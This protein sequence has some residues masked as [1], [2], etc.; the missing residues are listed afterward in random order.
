MTSDALAAFLGAAEATRL[1]QKN[2]GGRAGQAGTIYEQLFGAHRIS[3]LMKNLI[4]VGE[5]ADVEWPGDGFV[6]DFVVRKDEQLSFAAY[7]LKNAQQ[8]SWTAN[9]PNSI[10]DDFRAQRRI[11]E[12]ERYEKIELTLVCS[13][14]DVR[15]RL[16][17]AVPDE[18][19]PF[20][21]V[22]FFPFEG[23]L[24]DLMERHA[25]LKDDFGQVSRFDAPS[26]VQAEQIARVL[27]GLLPLRDGDM[28]VRALLK[29]A[30]STSPQ[31][32]R[33]SE[34]DQQAMQHVSPALR[35]ILEQLPGFSY[36]IRRGF[37][38][39]SVSLGSSVTKGTL[40]FD[41]SSDRFLTWQNKIIQIQP[42]AFVDIEEE[43]Q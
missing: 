25:W 29:R 35:A 37:L 23:S 18:I 10:C 28:S 16:S 1:A 5:D 40:S 2:R 42:S 36:Q 21:S 9:A 38:H 24:L 11:C 32:V 8:V 26:D 13:K 34:S 17:N 27:M 12:R 6:D 3:R 39:W 33:S 20:S 15:E 19:R 30:Q 41:C 22:E 14:L 31:L 7:Q 43:F 4:E